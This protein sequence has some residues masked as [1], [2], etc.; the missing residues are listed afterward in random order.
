MRK[1]ESKGKAG[2]QPVLSCLC[3]HSLRVITRCSCF[4]CLLAL[5]D[6][7]TGYDPDHRFYSSGECYF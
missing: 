5:V 2:A 1:H 7:E 6:L 4:E 3:F